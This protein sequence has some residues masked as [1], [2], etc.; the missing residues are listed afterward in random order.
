MRPFFSIPSL[1]LARGLAVGLAAFA[2]LAPARLAAYA[3]PTNLPPF[4]KATPLETNAGSGIKLFQ[5][6][7]TPF[8]VPV[9][10][11]QG[12]RQRV[13]AD[14]EW[15]QWID[16]KRVAVDAWM[17]RH[18]DRPEW[19]P[20]GSHDFVSPADGSFLIWTEDVPG[21]PVSDSPG[22]SV[23]KLHSSTG[24]DV[25]P[26][27][28][29][30]AA[31]VTRFRNRHTQMMVEAAN[32]YQ[33]TG[34]TRYAGWVAGQLDFYA[35]N[36]LRWPLTLARGSPARLGVDAF[37]D[38]TTLTR[39][40]E[41]A[42]LVFPYAAP[43]RRQAWLDRLFVP[44]VRMLEQSGQNI[45]NHGVWLRAA[46][47][48]VA[49]L[50]NDDAMWTRAADLPWGLRDQLLRGVT[51]DYFWYEQSV[52]YNDYVLMAMRPL[53]TLAGLT[54][55]RH[56]LLTEAAIV[57]N[58]MLTT[59][60]LRFPDGTVPNPSDSTHTYRAPAGR[61]GHYYRVLPTTLGLE[62]ASRERTWDTLV[63]PPPPPPRPPVVPDVVSRSFES[64]RFAVLRQGR[65]Q[66]FFHY[67]QLERSHTQAEALNWTA[68]FDGFV[69]NR[70]PGTVG[71]GSPLSAGYFKRG[72]NHNVPL[73]N[74]E[75][76][77]PWHPGTL[78]R[79]DASANVVS[80]EQ[81]HYR[82]DAS[83]RRTLRI[84]AA[85]DSLI[86]ETTITLTGPADV[87]S[88]AVTA[89]P[90]LGLSLHLD[91]T[92]RL[93]PGFTPVTDDDFRRDRPEPFTCWRDIRAAAFRDRAAFTVE[94]EGG[95][96]LRVELA[97]PGEFTLYQGS[98]PD[99]PPHRRAG[100]Y[101]EKTGRETAATFTTT[102]TPV[103][104]D[105]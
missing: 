33:F 22:A 27:P 60:F 37:E 39:F 38:A 97:T 78:L 73:V 95:R 82:D 87:S 11:W 46:Q 49:L 43:A 83:A 59:L 102:F 98:S 41:A 90:R 105:S 62:M 66:L 53:L 32:L 17:A 57:Q 7:G 61:M 2:A 44:E 67:G 14:P 25:E 85:T 96:V 28:E 89:S 35:D 4:P 94:F 47:C 42:R 68:S 8:R 75:G 80:A 20:G 69:I 81:P 56:R 86:D 77:Q 5:P 18:R 65:W 64:S 45:H 30:L 36:L 74:G 6:E 92:P 13:A 26:T 19:I 50:Y 76:Q 21:E 93:P 1:L 72:L 3:R 71:Y 104:P 34:D 9:E 52:A 101:I 24:H 58:M 10:D 31:W 51:S 40:V 99:R 103:R 100:F 15:Q 12:A 48:M 91:G 16:E 79:F 23:A 88:S 63:D 29:I 55:N 84:D 54:G 70:D